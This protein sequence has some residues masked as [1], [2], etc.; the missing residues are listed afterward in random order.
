[1]HSGLM[2]RAKLL[3]NTWLEDIT[4]ALR[5][6]GGTAKYADL[7]AEIQNSREAELSTAW[8]EIV[9]RT[10]QNHS[11]DS[12][13][14]IGNSNG[15][16]LFFAVEGIGKGIWGLREMAEAT[17][18]SSEIPPDLDTSELLDPPPGESDSGVTATG[19]ESPG[20]VRTETYR[21][22]RDTKLARQVKLLHRNH[23]QVCDHIIETADGKG[24]SEAH[25]VIPLGGVHAGPDTPSN[26]LVLCPNH[27]AEMDMG[28]MR[29]DPLDLRNVEGHELSQDSI[30]YHNE[31]IFQMIT[32]ATDAII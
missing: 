26:I 4:S 30:D 24:Y 13:A 17:L 6:L 25:H 11:S 5:H 8:Q 27:H 3:A 12:R 7:Y 22:L 14:F 19:S 21:I 20:R 10:I 16:D 32:T 28:L 2:K 15:K 1:M 18:R 31:K 9:R 29:L 23:C